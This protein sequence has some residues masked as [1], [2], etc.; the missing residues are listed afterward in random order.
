MD[1][2]PQNNYY[3]PTVIESDGRGERAFDIYSR[4]LKDRIIFIGTGIDDG[5]ANSVIAQMLFLQMQDPKKDIHIYINSPG[6]SVT[7]GLAIYDTM[8]FLTCDVNTYC[9]GIAA[10]MGA[11]LLTAGTEGK[12]FCLPNSHVMIHQVSGGAQGTAAD[13]ERT[14]GFMFGLKKRLNKILAHHTGKSEEQVEK[15]ADRDNYMSAEE[16]AAYG[17]VDKVLESRKELPL[18]EDSKNDSDDGKK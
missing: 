10:S 15:D 7:A 1:S 11:V 8:Q 4:L 2:T 6:G 16:S 3:I 17:L 9:I 13:V 14:I 5:V 12:R 18:T